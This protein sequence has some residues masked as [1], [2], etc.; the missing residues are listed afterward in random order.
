MA[1]LSSTATAARCWWSTANSVI[2]AIVLHANS[3]SGEV[4]SRWYTPAHAL[5]GWRQRLAARRERQPVAV[6]SDPAPTAADP[7]SSTHGP[8]AVSPRLSEQLRLFED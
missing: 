4:W 7:A 1:I 5:G 6:P 2:P 8:S 3:L